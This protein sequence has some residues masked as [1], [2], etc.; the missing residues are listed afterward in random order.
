MM[1]LFGLLAADSAIRKIRIIKIAR[2]IKRAKNCQ[3][4]YQFDG[5][6]NNFPFFI[7]LKQRNWYNENRNKILFSDMTS[8]M[9]SWLTFP[10]LALV[11]WGLSDFFPKLAMGFISSNSAVVYQSVGAAVIGAVV[12]LF[13]VGLKPESDTRG[14]I[15]SILAGMTLM[16]GY[17]FFTIALSKGIKLSVVVPIAALY[18]IVTIALA[19]LILKE[20]VTLWQ[21]IGMV[22]ALAAMIFFT[23]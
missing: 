23:L 20:S 14:I 17:L 8:K 3:K 11:F 7:V 2:S 18:P 12:L 22:L 5:K 15:F 21:G 16:L 13:L 10:I 6:L 1:T 19:F 4:K 9:N